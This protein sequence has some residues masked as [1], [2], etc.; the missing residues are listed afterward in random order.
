MSLSRILILM[1]QK[2]EPDNG[3][4]KQQKISSQKKNKEKKSKIDKIFI[5][6]IEQQQQQ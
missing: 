2:K 5:K 3:H 1:I 4:M 6:V